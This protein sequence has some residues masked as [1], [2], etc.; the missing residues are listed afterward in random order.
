MLLPP[1][2]VMLMVCVCVREREREREREIVLYQLAR[3]EV[4]TAVRCERSI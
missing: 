2:A 4:S 3:H 1:V